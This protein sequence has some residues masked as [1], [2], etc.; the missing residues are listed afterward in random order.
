MLVET[1]GKSQET[2]REFFGKLGYKVLVT[3]NPQRALARFST[4]PVPADCLVLSAHALGDS[5]IDAFNVLSKDVFFSQVPAILLIASK[6]REA[7][8][9]AVEDSRR[10]VLQTPFHAADMSKLL[11]ELIGR[12]A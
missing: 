4:T 3:E 2:L 9:R 6:Q 10:K 7:A 11:G 1:T 5:A 8:S 12:P